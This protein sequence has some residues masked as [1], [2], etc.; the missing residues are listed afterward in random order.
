LFHAFALAPIPEAT[1]ALDEIARFIGRD[2]PRRRQ[3][4]LATRRSVPIT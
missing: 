3:E 2:P 4:A 1:Q